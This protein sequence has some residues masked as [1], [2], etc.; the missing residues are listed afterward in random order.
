MLH[1][2]HPVYVYGCT[3]SN[4]EQS[5][6]SPDTGEYRMP[7]HRLQ[8]YLSAIGTEVACEVAIFKR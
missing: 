5:G 6:E 1:S 2:E 8:K 4:S 3:Y 7:Q